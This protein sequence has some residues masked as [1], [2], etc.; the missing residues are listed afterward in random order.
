MSLLKEPRKPEKL[1]CMG[2][3]YHVSVQGHPVIIV[4]FPPSFPSVVCLFFTGG[5]VRWWAIITQ[6]AAKLVSR[7]QVGRVAARE[8][9][10]SSHENFISRL[11]LNT[12]AVIFYVPHDAGSYRKP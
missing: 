11:L 9:I 6:I 7:K 4:T 10:N 5:T 12:V 3:V 8:K 2:H 1:L